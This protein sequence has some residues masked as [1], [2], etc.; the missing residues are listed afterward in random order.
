MRYVAA[1][2]IL[3][4]AACASSDE[5]H[6]VQKAHSARAGILPGQGIPD[7]RDGM[8]ASDTGSILWVCANSA[9]HE[10]KEVYLSICPSCSQMNYFYWDRAQEGYRCYACLKNVDNAIIKCPEC[11][12]PPR[13]MRTKPVAK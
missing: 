7:Q 13:R 2:V 5:P 8:S 1:L 9:K 6:I 4:L 12:Q 11:G 10:D 3:G